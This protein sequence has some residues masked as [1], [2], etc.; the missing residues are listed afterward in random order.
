MRQY[1]E[2]LWYVYSIRIIR[3]ELI[4]RI[5]P[6]NKENGSKQKKKKAVQRVMEEQHGE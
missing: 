2:K 5:F 1:G 6:Q 4:F 3:Y